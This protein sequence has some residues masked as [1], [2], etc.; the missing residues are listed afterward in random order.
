MKAHPRA[1][2]PI[3][4]GAS[5]P[6]VASPGPAWGRAIRAGQWGTARAT[7][8]GSTGRS[9]SPNADDFATMRCS[10][11]PKAQHTARHGTL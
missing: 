11:N 10:G 6:G 3:P 4:E 7:V 5:A 8:R 2:A 1:M 9:T